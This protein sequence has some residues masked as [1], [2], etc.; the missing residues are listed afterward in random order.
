MP[1]ARVRWLANGVE[2]TVDDRLKRGLTH[3]A[4]AHPAGVTTC[5]R[6]PARRDNGGAEVRIPFPASSYCG[7]CRSFTCE[8]ARYALAALSSNPK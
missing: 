8:G 3:K 5:I 2:V 6:N 1:A 4:R 7:P